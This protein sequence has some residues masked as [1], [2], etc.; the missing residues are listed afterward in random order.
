MFRLGLPLLDFKNPSIQAL[1]ITWFAF[2]VSFFVWF[3]HAPLMGLITEAFNLNKQQI[4]ALLILNVALTIPSRIIVGSL[5]DQLGPRIVFSGILVI[6]GLLC[7][8][9]GLAQT[10]E[11]LAM[12]RFLLGFVGSSFVVGMRMVSEWFPAKQLGAAEGVYG[13][14]GNFGAAVAAMILPFLA[15]VWGGENGWRFALIISGIFVLGYGFFY[16]IVA[17]DTP[18]GSTYFKP[19]KTGGLEVSNK[20]DLIFYIL[21]NLPMAFALCLIIWKLSPSGINLLSENTAAI[22]YIFS[23]VLLIVQIKQILRVNQEMLKK[24]IPCALQYSF[25]QVA[26]LAACYFVAFGSEI[27]VVSMLPMF[28]MKTFGLSAIVAG[29]VAGC[30]PLMNL[31]ARPIGGALSDH[32]GRK[33]VLTIVFVGLSCGFIL[34]GQ[35]NQ[36]WPVYLAVLACLFCSI[37]VQAGAGAVCAVVPLIQR[38]MTGQIAGIVGAYGNIGGAIYLTILSFVESSVFFIVIGLSAFA[39]LVLC[40]LLQEPSGHMAEVMPDG[41]LKLIE[42]S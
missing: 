38:R 15:A 21:M 18:K 17:R 34:M 10:F 41:S 8:L 1:H 6:A 39:A 23:A 13:G 9:F 35:I 28:F 12:M 2:F 30:F 31:F 24:P 33:K 40:Q 19:K 11:Q 22:L 37:F 42:V 25:K 36:E 5:V 14:W 27:A 32:F 29:L 3:A 16:Y 4:S 7:I 26:I 20:K